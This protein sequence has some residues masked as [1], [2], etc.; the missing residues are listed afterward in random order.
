M[1]LICDCLLVSYKI[2]SRKQSN[3]MTT[4]YVH[5]LCEKPDLTLPF[6]SAK[7]PRPILGILVVALDIT[8]KI[9][10]L[11]NM[12]LQAICREWYINLEI[13]KSRSS[14]NIAL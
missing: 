13:M 9:K 4:I 5:A 8:I 6:T 2:D 12:N 1:K 3:N 10:K 11:S 14:K 7:M